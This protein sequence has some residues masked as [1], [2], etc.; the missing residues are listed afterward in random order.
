MSLPEDYNLI[1]EEHEAEFRLDKFLTLRFANLSRTYF[2]W[3]IS[4]GHVSVNGT[5]VKKSAKLDPGAEIEVQ[6]VPTRELDL[7]P[8]NIPLDILYE[9]DWMIAV[10][11]PA[12]LVVHPGP[13]NWKGTFVNALLYH[14]TALERL[15]RHDLRPGIVHRLDKETTGVLLAAKTIEMHAKLQSLFSKREIMKRYFAICKGVPKACLID[16]SIGR[17]AR[18]RKRMAVVDGGGKAARTHI[19][20]LA[21]NTEMSFLD[22]NLETGRTHQIRVHLSH[23]GHPVLGDSLYGHEAFNTRHSATRQMLHAS[24]LSFVHPITGIQLV[25]KADLPQDM[26]LLTKRIY[27]GSSSAGDECPGD[28]QPTASGQD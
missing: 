11:K 1:V 18:D 23:I 20:S 4:E 26:L 22:I 8:E 12:G 27:E 21:S 2:Q 13:G 10:N 5:P 14:V 17:D 19:K 28:C 3:L 16:A 15:N 24:E 25:I 7:E 9:D 6:F